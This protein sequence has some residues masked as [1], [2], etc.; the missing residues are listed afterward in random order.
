MR[1]ISRSRFRLGAAAVGVAALTATASMAALSTTAYAGPTAVAHTVSSPV[2]QVC[3]AA[4]AGYDRCLAE[5]RTDVHE[6]LG[7][8]GRA[9]AAV[10]G[11]A[12]ALPSGFG[13]A[14]L[15]AAYKL[16][17]T[18]G[19]N[20]TV[21]IVDAGDDATAEADLAVYRST[22][23]LPACTTANGCFRKVNQTGASAPLPKDQGWGIEI[24]LDVD[25]VSAACPQCHILLVESDDAYSQN[26]AASVDTA[27]R[28]GA[29]EVSNSY[30]ATE[31]NGV[32]AYAHDYAHPGVAIFAS[33]GDSGYGIPI[34]PAAYSSVIAVGGTSLT[35]DSSARGWSETAWGGAGSGCSAWIDKPTWQKD[36]DCPGRMTADVSAD[37][38]PNTGPAVYDTDP[39]DGTPGWGVV[40]GTSAA[41]PFLAGVVAQAGN[42]AKFPNA[43]ALYA[44]SATAGL[45]DVAG[46]ADGS[47]AGDYLCTAV[48]GYD[49]PTGLGTPNGLSAF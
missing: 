39:H 40:G 36:P 23:G 30:G 1:L 48:P 24:A 47:C 28:L 34:V 15:Q 29:T 5:V 8:R 2:R 4:K 45:N 44:P 10:T 13:P 43:S 17:S 18:G 38:D 3:G 22:Y 21:A 41:S 14:D 11:R 12:T 6:G 33:S 9:A 32:Q 16:P 25:M 19:T 27:V 46:G 37:A 7:V 20:Q 31:G 26:L 49:G 35:K 42:P